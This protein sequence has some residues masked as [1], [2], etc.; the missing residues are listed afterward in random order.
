M[1][2]K[3]NQ[4]EKIK[5]KIALSWEVFE[6]LNHIIKNSYIAINL[7][8]KVYNSCILPVTT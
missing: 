6:K 1:I 5:R 4:S 7:K 8:R 3:E 2:G